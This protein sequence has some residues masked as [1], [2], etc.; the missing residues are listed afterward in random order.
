MT[1]HG[2]SKRT[3]HSAESDCWAS[4]KRVALGAAW[5]LGSWE[6]ELHP[7]H[8]A[9]FYSKVNMSDGWDRRTDQSS[10]FSNNQLRTC[11]SIT[12]HPIFLKTYPSYTKK[13]LRKGNDF[14]FSCHDYSMLPVRVYSTQ[15]WWR[16]TPLIPALGKQKQA[17]R[18]VQV[19]S[20]LQRKFQNSQS[21]TEKP[22]L[23]KKDNNQKLICSNGPSSQED[24]RGVG[25]TIGSAHH[26]YWQ[27]QVHC[28]DNQK[29]QKQKS[30]SFSSLNSPLPWP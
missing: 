23:E 2:F 11:S 7:M 26:K 29:S 12:W 22:W 25:L 30:S 27:L 8:V 21:Y 4:R 16:C 6:M 28:Y 18:W 13:M 1:E 20:D 19:Q 9:M 5:G 14:L 15:W 3:S 17:D 24:E 10:P